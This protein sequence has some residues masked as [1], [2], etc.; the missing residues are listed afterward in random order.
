MQVSAQRIAMLFGIIPAQEKQEIK[1][2]NPTVVEVPITGHHIT[3]KEFKE[4]YGQML[5]RGMMS[6]EQLFMNVYVKTQGASR[7]YTIRELLNY[8]DNKIV[9]LDKNKLP[10]TFA[11]D[12]ITGIAIQGARKT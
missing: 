1:K 12:T 3:S 5:S 7:C 2:E 9:F 10:T 6:K 8:D 4:A 11:F